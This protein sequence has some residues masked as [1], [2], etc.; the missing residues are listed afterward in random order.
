MSNEDNQPSRPSLA[1]LLARR[2]GETGAAADSESRQERR[3]S[4]GTRDEPILSRT[5]KRARARAGSQQAD[6]APPPVGFYPLPQ[7]AQPKSWGT[8]ISFLLFVVIP[9]VLATIYYYGIATR[10]H[11]VEFRFAVRD[12][13]SSISGQT[14]GGSI[15]SVATG[16]GGMQSLENYMVVE[17]L[18]SESAVEEV[19]KR[20]DIRGMFSREN[21]DRFSR[22]DPSLPLEGLVAY[23]KGMVRTSYDQ[24]TGISTVQVRSFEAKDAFLIATTLVE[25]SEALITDISRRPQQDAVRFAEEDLRRAQ[26]RLKSISADMTSFRD[27]ERIIEPNT[28]VVLSNAQLAASLRA[29]LSQLQTELATLAKQSIAADAPIRM[30][31]ESRIRAAKEQLAIV[32]NEV[33]ASRGS[34]KPLSQVVGRYESLVLD[35]TFA[36]DMVN[37]ALRNLE[38]ARANA[39]MQHMYVT[40]FAQPVLPQS[41][42]RPKQLM[43]VLLTALVCLILW[44][45]GLLLFR[46]MREQIV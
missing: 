40:P 15:L 2:R 12:A 43:S 35:R 19:Q 32:E 4:A 23:W 17:Y 9:V 28:T 36:Q 38:T 34:D 18:L 6:Q 33:G 8:R 10:Q 3:L 44:S 39:L 24:V 27:L 26:E 42:T 37:S 16:R 14:E 5:E 46:S 1:D 7:R 30:V 25:M 21:I 29:N 41:A 20:I 22:F 45:A 13:Q 31:L 11:L